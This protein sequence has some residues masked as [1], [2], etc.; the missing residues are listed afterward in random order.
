M[1]HAEVAHGHADEHPPTT[2]RGYVITG[3]ILTGITVVELWASYSADVL[4]GVLVP[5][6]LIMS[7]VKF[8][9]VVAVFMHLRYDARLLRRLFIMGLMLATAI[10][11]ALMTLFGADAT[12]AVGGIVH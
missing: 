6:L 8:A 1:E 11:I 7:A 3:L 9:I 5:F 2:V 10:M 12:D 4:G